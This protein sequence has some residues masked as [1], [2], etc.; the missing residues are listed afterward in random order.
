MGQIVKTL[1]ICD[2]GKVA[3]VLHTH[4]RRQK[5]DDRDDHQW[6]PPPRQGAQTIVILPALNLDA[7]ASSTPQLQWFPRF[8]RPRRRSRRFAWWRLS[9]AFLRCAPYDERRV[10]T[11]SSDRCSRPLHFHRYSSAVIVPVFRKTSKTSPA[12]CPVTGPTRTVFSSMISST[13]VSMSYFVFRTQSP[14][15]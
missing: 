8:K 9:D 13:S 4:I 3:V 5:Q 15:T 2:P 14:R 10:R 12:L 7:A 6:R 11:A 1:A